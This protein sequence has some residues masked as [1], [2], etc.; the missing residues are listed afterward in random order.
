MSTVHGWLSS[1]RF[2]IPRVRS[3]IRLALYDTRST[4]VLQINFTAG[5]VHR[6]QIYGASRVRFTN[7]SCLRNSTLS[8][9]RNENYIF[10]LLR[11]WW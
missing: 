2:R 10:E 11:P 5:P 6:L 9:T 3:C 7:S 4:R 1:P 8:H